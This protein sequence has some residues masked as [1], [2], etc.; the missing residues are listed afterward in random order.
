MEDTYDDEV[1]EGFVEFL[2]NAIAEILRSEDPEALAVWLRENGP[3]QAPELFGE[4]ENDEARRRYAGILGRSLWNSIPLPGNGFRPRPIPWPERNDP[5]L[6][7]SGQK[8]KKC[9]SEWAAGMPELEP[10]AI[11]RLTVDELSLE[12]VEKLGESGRVPRHIV[13]DLA[14][15]VLDDGDPE[16]ALALVR[17]LFGRAERLDERD[18]AA[19]NTL[20]EAYDELELDDEKQAE[21]ERLAKVLRPALRGVLWENLV[22]SQAVAGDMEDAWETLEK[23]RKDNPRSPALGPLEVSLLLAQGKM[24][25]AG[26]RA[27][28][29]RERLRGGELTEEGYRYLDR[30][31]TDPEKAQIEFSLGDEVA[32]RLRKLEETLARTPPQARYAVEESGE[33]PGTLRLLPQQEIEEVE[34]AWMNVFAPSP[35]EGLEPDEEWES[36]DETNAEEWL[37]FL[38]ENP[39]ALDSFVVLDEVAEAFEE[40][41]ADLP[42]VADSL[43]PYL[44]DRGTAILDLAL[45][46][47]PEPRLERNPG[48]ND[49][50]LGL[51]SAGMYRAQRLEDLEA[52]QAFDAR[53]RALDPEH[54][55]WSDEETIE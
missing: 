21:V 1:P 6:C 8:Y 51:L 36:W 25:E 13:G 54:P 37:A 49:S 30:V 28:Y 19:L 26:E 17:P 55:L 22:R 43:L 2:R 42:A 12:Q 16:R 14:T 11:W 31:A 35:V 27:R 20:L 50:V 23:A 46:G 32:V 7:G 53:R 9:C 33:E 4:L 10:E 29:W 34:D 48:S 47:R 40:L 5:C 38:V 24:A 3:V 15:A 45:A 41:A 44:I 39:V 52:A 18:A